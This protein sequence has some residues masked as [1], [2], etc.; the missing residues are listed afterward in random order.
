MMKRPVSVTDQ[1]HSQFALKPDEYKDCN[2]YIKFN[3]VIT[4]DDK[5]ARSGKQKFVFLNFFNT[6]FW[7]SSVYLEE[8]IVSTDG[9]LT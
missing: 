8:K 5:W 2:N 4:N 3:K 1:F 7:T 6:P 9:G